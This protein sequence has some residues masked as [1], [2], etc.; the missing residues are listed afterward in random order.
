MFPL[1][2]QVDLSK[3][4]TANLT[5]HFAVLCATLQYFTYNVL[6]INITMNRS[7]QKK[8]SDILKKEFNLF[9]TIQQ[10]DNL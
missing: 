9:G 8:L 6:H 2:K 5:I 3:L 1:P 10:T 4:T 7:T